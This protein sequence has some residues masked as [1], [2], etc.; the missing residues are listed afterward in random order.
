MFI[1]DLAQEVVDAVYPFIDKLKASIVLHSMTEVMRLNKLDSFRKAQL[2]Q[3]KSIIRELIKKKKESDGAS[4]KDA[5][6]KLLNTLPSILLKYL[7]HYFFRLCRLLQQV[8][9]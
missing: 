9:N 8:H 3:A 6:L 5:M 1:E 2:G 4:F 7:S